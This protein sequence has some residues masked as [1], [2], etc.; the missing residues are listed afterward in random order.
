MK[1]IFAESNIMI[2]FARSKITREHSSAGSEHLPYK[3]RA[4]GSNPSAPTV[5]TKA[6]HENMWDF[7][8]LFAYNLHTS[9]RMLLLICNSI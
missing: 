2:I 5:K 9:F 8:F 4:G 3:K 6:L 1:N 7:V